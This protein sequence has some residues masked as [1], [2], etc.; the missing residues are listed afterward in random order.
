MCSMSNMRA[1]LWLISFNLLILHVLFNAVINV[2]AIFQGKV[3][4]CGYKLSKI[5]Y[6]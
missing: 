2:R 4:K 3:A 6:A 1:T 5:L